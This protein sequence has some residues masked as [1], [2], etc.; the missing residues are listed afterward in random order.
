[1]PDR[2]QKTRRI[3]QYT[4]AALNLW[5]AGQFLLWVLAFERG[6]EPTVSRPAGVDGWLPIAGLMNTKY[7]FSTGQIPAIHPAAMVLFLAFCAIS[8]VAKKAFCSW[9]CP[10]GTLSEH[11]ALLGRKLFGKNLRLPR[12]LDVT[13]RGL[14]YLLLGFFVI[15]IVGMSAEVLTDFLSTPYGILADVKMLGFFRH[16]GPVALLVLTVLAA[17]SLV[18][19][20]FWCRY[21]CPYGALM[22]LLS[23]ASPLKIRRRVALCT[24]CGHCARACPAALAVDKLVQ[25][26]SAEC[27]ACM[28]CVA[29]CPT[30][31]ALQFSLPI[32]ET[33]A[34]LPRYRRALTPTAFAI[35][36]AALFCGFV[37]AARAT[38]HW[39]THIPDAVYRQLIPNAGQ[40]AHPG[41][42]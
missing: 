1:M 25:V 37:L 16:L 32:V 24:G 34:P 4:F 6:V 11:L 29:S 23:L 10:I 12:A 17:L 30:E 8:L 15:F 28:H 3:V 9:L 39:Q 26:R 36:I 20:Q 5:I 18:V 21:L 40:L 35:L 13:L 19:E 14:K 22:G 42:R 41:L 33:S 38:D 31:G 27:T 7:F 2:F